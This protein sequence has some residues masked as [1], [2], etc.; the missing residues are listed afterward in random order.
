MMAD[1]QLG[2]GR[3]I[4]SARVLD[5]LRRVLRHEFVPK[6]LRASAYDDNPLPI[7]F[8]QTIS[9]PF[10]VAFM[11]QKLDPLP[12]DRVLEVG[13]G[14]GY[15]TA[16]LAELVKE[17]YTI[18][19]LQPLARRAETDLRRLGYT[20]IQL[21]FGDGYQGWPEAAP[22]DSIIV[23]CAPQA[24]P[25]PL[26]AQLKEGGKMIIPVGPLGHQ[27]LVLLCKK[28]GR[29]E[30][31][32]VLPVSFVPMTGQAEGGQDGSDSLGGN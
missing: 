26:I 31:H 19:I 27:Q 21:R 1:E 17:V 29:L 4:T 18:E 3:G 14:S 12:T 16:V 23:T 2:S 25:Q 5:A 22:F 32:A 11:T 9:Q 7:G 20:N 13:S 24:V 8:G 15:Q 6:G 10:V 28:E 30:K